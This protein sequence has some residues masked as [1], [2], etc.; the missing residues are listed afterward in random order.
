VGTGVWEAVVKPLLENW[1]PERP[2]ERPIV[3]MILTDGLID[4]VEAD[5][6]ERAM[7]RAT[8][9][10]RNS[11]ASGAIL[12]QFINFGT[13]VR[14]GSYKVR[15]QQVLEVFMNH[16][17]LGRVVDVLNWETGTSTLP[18]KFRIYYSLP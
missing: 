4:P 5:I 6:L 1:K 11:R 7:L 15:G 2:I 12:F 3:V 13:P 16:P 8:R 10:M 17:E 18:R 14:C 9:K